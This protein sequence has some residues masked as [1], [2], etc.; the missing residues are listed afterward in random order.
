MKGFERQA[1]DLKAL[2]GYDDEQEQLRE[3]YE[4]EERELAHRNAE[5]DSMKQNLKEIGDFLD[6]C[7]VPRFSGSKEM[8]ILE[9]IES[10]IRSKYA[11]VV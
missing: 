6:N 1:D 4:E 10:A 5:F 2:M 9:R 7:G 3:V 11:R 8:T